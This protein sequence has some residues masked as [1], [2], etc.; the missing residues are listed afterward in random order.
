M[1]A[2]VKDAFLVREIC[3]IPAL[4]HRLYVLMGGK[5]AFLAIPVLLNDEVRVLKKKESDVKHMPN[6]EE[7]PTRSEF[8]VDSVSQCL[9]SFP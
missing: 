5:F 7:G 8:V 4:L 6:L 9:C 3:I 2:C 1:Q